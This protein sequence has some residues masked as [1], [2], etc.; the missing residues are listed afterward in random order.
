MIDSK[1]PY[2][3]PDQF[4]YIDKAESDDTDQDFS[5]LDEVTNLLVRYQQQ[6]SSVFKLAMLEWKLSLRSLYFVLLLTICFALALVVM[7]IGVNLLIGFTLIKLGLPIF[8]SLALV[9]VMQTFLL[10]GLW[11][12][13]MSLTKK[14]GFNRTLYALEHA[15]NTTKH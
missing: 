11:A 4:L 3:I 8:L 13:I 6:L 9:V 14:V 12:N 7:W 1:Q 10:F 2:P 15:Y 5:F